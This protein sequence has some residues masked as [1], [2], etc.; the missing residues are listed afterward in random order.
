MNLNELRRELDRATHGFPRQHIQR[1][2]EFRVSYPHNISHYGNPNVFDSDDCFLYAFGNILPSNL[3]DGFVN[4]IEK[5]HR[6]FDDICRDLITEGF[7]SLHNEKRED[8]RIVVYL[9]GNS[10]KHFGKIE[11]DSVVSKWGRGYTWKHGLFEV[12]LSYGD[13]VKFSNGTIDQG[14]FR[15]VIE[16]HSKRSDQVKFE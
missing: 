15:R 3:R 7:L 5:K 4:L 11:G 6:A 2:A 13:T 8:D 14:V 1:I 9:Y 16:T 12:P 10:V